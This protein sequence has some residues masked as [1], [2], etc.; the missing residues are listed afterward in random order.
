MDWLFWA[1][2]SETHE[3]HAS[4]R[5]GAFGPCEIH[6]I[7]SRLRDAEREGGWTQET[8]WWCKDW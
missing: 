8:S 4:R 7:G 1:D 5:P 2:L 3:C 6:A